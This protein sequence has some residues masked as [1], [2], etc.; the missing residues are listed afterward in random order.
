MR[1]ERTNAPRHQSGCSGY[2]SIHGGLSLR[3][4]VAVFEWLDIDCSHGAVWN[5]AHTL[6]EAQADPPTAKST[7]VAVNGEKK[8]LYA[9]VQL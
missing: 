5:W 2:V 4:V 6:L 7:R 8:W 3:E 1:F 9:A